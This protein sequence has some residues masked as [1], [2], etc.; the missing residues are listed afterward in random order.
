MLDQDGGL[1]Q[2]RGTQWGR[3]GPC[4]PLEAL[5]RLRVGGSLL[6][7]KFERQWR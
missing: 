4:L 3:N 2:V 1:S 6:G 5:E 7:K